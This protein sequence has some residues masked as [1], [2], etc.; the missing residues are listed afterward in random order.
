[1]PPVTNVPDVSLAIDI[2]RRLIGEEPGPRRVNQVARRK[3]AATPRA[4][5]HIPDVTDSLARQLY[6]PVEWL[7]KTV[8]LLNE[9]RQLIFYGPPG[10]GKT[11]V[12]QAL[13]EHIRKDAKGEWRLVQ[14]H[15][16]YSYEDFFEGYRPSRSEGEGMLHFDLRRGP[17]RL[18]AEAAAKDP[19]H[20]YLLVIDEIN[21]GNIA[22]IFGE[23]YFLL[24]YR[25]R[26]VGLQ[27]SP[28]QDFELP[29]NLFILGTMNTADRSIA[30][31]D[32]ALRRRFYF[33]P[34]L[35]REWP[36]REVL[37]RWLRTKRY[38][39]EPARLLDALNA[40]LH[41]AL[42]D[43]DFAFGPSYFM[44]KGGPPD[45]DRI[46]RYAIH[47]LLEERFYGE[48]RAEELE[49]DFGL[50]AVRTRLSGSD[51][52]A[53]EPADDGEEPASPT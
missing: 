6:L 21:R 42:P 11:F 53:E 48:R 5:W 38:D 20:P 4:P 27:Y 33:F 22:K 52:S 45:L 23:L 40:A 35:P 50:A 36:V 8:S 49:R 19:E 17:L 31:I 1:V 18:I 37:A 10:T 9:K 7:Q 46:W 2:A 24:E 29:E 39:D 43:D 34:F 14:F 16:A 41:E 28:E 12:A 25:D 13:G 30:L 44:A 47:P 51:A 15:P 26:P 32:S 3:D